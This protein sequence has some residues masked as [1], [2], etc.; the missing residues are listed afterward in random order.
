MERSV[1]LWMKERKQQQRNVYVFFWAASKGRLE[2]RGPRNLTAS[3]LNR[4]AI[5]ATLH[6]TL[7]IYACV[8]A[9]QFHFC[10]I[11]PSVNP[12]QIKLYACLS[13]LQVSL[14]QRTVP[15][16]LESPDVG[17]FGCTCIIDRKHKPQLKIQFIRVAW[18]VK[19]L[20]RYKNRRHRSSDTV[21]GVKV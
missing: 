20:G 12:D 13:R 21:P 14:T 2:W 10:R 5:T 8:N 19:L 3:R 15:V 1:L 17:C 4:S 18:A 11:S 7:P 16:I 9:A 6:L